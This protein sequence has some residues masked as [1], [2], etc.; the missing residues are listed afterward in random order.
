MQRN[1]EIRNS[2][3]CITPRIFCRPNLPMT[4]SG[5]SDTFQLVGLSQFLQVLFHGPRRNIHFF[6]QFK[7]RQMASLA[8]NFKIISELFPELFSFSSK[9]PSPLTA[10]RYFRENGNS[11]QRSYPSTWISG[12]GESDL[13]DSDQRKETESRISSPSQNF[14]CLTL[15]FSKVIR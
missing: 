2:F 5:W 12:G 1:K 11:I 14:P 8:S 15:F 9:T 13:T 4:A 6:S 10:T 7:N 3:I